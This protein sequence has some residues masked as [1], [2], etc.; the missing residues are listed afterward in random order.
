MEKIKI[1][2]DNE[3]DYTKKKKTNEF[4]WMQEHAQEYGFILRYP[5]DKIEETGYMYESWH[6]RYVGEEVAKYIKENNISYEEYY[7]TKIKDWNE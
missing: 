6:Y 1:F 2:F 7:A 3:I 4:N 5:K